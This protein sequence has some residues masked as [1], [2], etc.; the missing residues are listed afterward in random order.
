[1]DIKAKRVT[2][3]SASV[4]DEVGLLAKIAHLWKEDGVDQAAV[5]AWVEDGTCHFRTAPKDL[6]AA[7]ACGLKVG[8]ELK[9]TPAIRIKGDDEVGALEPAAK[10]LAE[11]GVNITSVMAVAAGEKFSAILMV[12]DA[13]YE[14]ACKALGI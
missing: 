5:V 6:D 3:M 10:A 7:R 11:A 12:A 9:E 8:I 2:V 4:P 1:M 13:D 14:K